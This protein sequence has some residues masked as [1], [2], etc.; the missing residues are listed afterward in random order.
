MVNVDI[1]LALFRNEISGI[2]KLWERRGSA[3]DRDVTMVATLALHGCIPVL[4]T[5]HMHQKT[6]SIGRIFAF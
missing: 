5:Q 3:Q 6:F 4:G 2:C 1:V